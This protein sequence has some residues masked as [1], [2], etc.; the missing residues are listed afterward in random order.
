MALAQTIWT[1]L[2]FDALW[3]L[4]HGGM[5]Q[6]LPQFDHVDQLCDAC[7]AGKQRRAPFPQKAKYGA[8]KRLDL[9]HGDICGPV[10]PATHGGRSYFLL[11]VDDVSR[12]MWLELLSSKGE[13]AS[14]IKKFQAGVKVEMRRKL[15]A[16]RIDRGGEFTSISF[17]ESPTKALHDMTPYEAWYGKKPA[18]HFMRTFGCIAHVKLT[19]PHA[20]K[21]DD[22]S[23][24][25]VFVG[26][27]P[28]SRA[29]ESVSHVSAP[30]EEEQHTP[31]ASEQAEDSNGIKFISPSS[32]M[33]SGMEHDD[34]GAPRRY[35]TVADCVATSER[36]ELHLDELLLAASEEPNTFEEANSDPAWQAAMEEEMTAIV[37][38]DTWSLVD[39]STGHRPIGLKWVYKLKKDASG[40][41]I[42]HKARLVAKG[43]VQRAGID[44][45]EAFAPMARLDSVRALLA[46]T[47][48]EAWA[49]HH[50]DVKSAFL[51]R[52]LEEEVYVAQPLGFA[53]AGHERQVLK[54][55][56]ALYGLR[57]A[58]CAWNMKLDHTLVELGFCKCTDEHGVYT[59]GKS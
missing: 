36:Q 12:Y 31:L 9:V 38:N 57:Q 39:L 41:V 25:M 4:G 45:E 15:R 48:H 54:L 14:A 16:L 32:S 58:P 46:V 37:D 2:A 44:F 5:V 18:V 8:R 56:K 7:L 49:V 30:Y 24:K 11:L 52:D 6:G 17:G 33:P 51:N 13:A 28:D 26:Y 47:A 27:E 1:S 35:R 50:L 40:A 59:S 20:K 23:I 53:V 22:M 21:L 3:K 10:T 55:R 43:Y 19:R 42:R 29:T 34:E